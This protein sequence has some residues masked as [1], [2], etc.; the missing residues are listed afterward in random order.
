MLKLILSLHICRT[1][2]GMKITMRKPVKY[3]HN[4]V[5]SKAERIVNPL[6]ALRAGQDPVQ[7]LRDLREVEKYSI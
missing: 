4:L 7:A 6:Q 5:S 1:G 3:I 2:E